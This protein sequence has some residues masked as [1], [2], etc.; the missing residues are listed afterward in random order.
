MGAMRLPSDHAPVFDTIDYVNEKAKEFD[1]P[2]IRVIPY[3]YWSEDLDSP[4]K[5]STKIYYVRSLNFSFLQKH[6]SMSRYDLQK[7]GFDI[8]QQDMILQGASLATKYSQIVDPLTEK[9][10]HALK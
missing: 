3:Y 1:I 2:L 5:T 10:G 9:V 8:K 6:L 7:S 4:K